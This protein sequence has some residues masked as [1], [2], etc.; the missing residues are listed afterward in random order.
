MDRFPCGSQHLTLQDEV[1]SV[2]N[3]RSEMVNPEQRVLL[4]PQ[5]SFWS[6]MRIY[7]HS[8]VKADD[9]DART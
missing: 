2:W 9:H 6:R 8:P 7:L 5:H 4:Y 3:I 1:R